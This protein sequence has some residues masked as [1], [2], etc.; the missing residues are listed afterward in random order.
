MPI[1]YTQA[2][3]QALLA[4]LGNGRQ[5]AIVAR[6]LAQLLG[7]PVGGNQV[8][9]RGLIKECIEVDGDLIGATTGRP[10]GFFIITSINELETYLDSLEN[11][12]RSDNERRTALIMSW[13]NQPN[14]PNTIKQTLTIQ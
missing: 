2:Q 10:A 11:R 3:R 5:N 4:T 12:T 6:I 13:N 8:Q 9:L 1:N 14:I 7:Y